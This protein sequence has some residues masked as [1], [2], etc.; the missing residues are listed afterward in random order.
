MRPH[1]KNATINFAMSVHPYARTR[2]SLNGYPCNLMGCISKFL[3]R[4][5]FELII[6]KNNGYFR[7]QT[8]YNKIRD[9]VIY[10]GHHNWCHP[11][12]VLRINRKLR[13]RSFP[14]V[15]GV[16]HQIGKS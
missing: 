3:E 16:T 5:Q 6:D 13:R 7:T 12:S 4:F 10:A 8:I 14:R 15:S 1:Q 11:F 2:K 9:S